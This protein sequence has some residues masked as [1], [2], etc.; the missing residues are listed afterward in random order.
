MNDSHNDHEGE[1]EPRADDRSALGDGEA[2][3][4]HDDELQKLRDERDQFEQQLQRVMADT[5]NMR[6]RQQ[7]EMDD[8]RRRV[9]EGMTQELLPVLDTFSLALDAYD[10]SG[11]TGSVKALVDGVRMVRTL[12]TGVLE[13]HGLREIAAEGPFD[14]ARH[15]AV[16]VEPTASTPEGHVVR[17]LQTGYQLGEH[18]VRHSKVVVA[19]KA[20][21]AADRPPA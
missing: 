14:P 16:A 20:P 5:A 4:R 17:V 13:R 10:Q 6:R 11:D 18:V 21:P 19:G 15:E 3:G 12:L 9:V 8:S 1:H 7:K 2:G